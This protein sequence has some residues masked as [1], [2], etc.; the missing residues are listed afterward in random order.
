[1]TCTTHSPWAVPPSFKPLFEEPELNTFAYLDSAIAAFVK[2]IED[3]PTLRD[4]TLL[5]VL[6]DHTSVT[7]G[8][9]LLERLRIP[10][11][12]YAPGLPRVKNSATLCASQVDV[13]PTVLGLMKGEH[14]YAGMGRNLLSAKTRCA[15]VVSGTRDTGFYVTENWV[16][17]YRPFGGASQLFAVANGMVVPQDRAAEQTELV[18]QLTKACFARIELARRL[19]LN[20]RVYPMESEIP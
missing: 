16:L 13:L 14:R 9:N 2:R 8:N 15:G 18:Q 4:K 1:M 17:Q 3:T 11:I 10:L 20:R 12:F 6:G 19:S 5:V 7:F